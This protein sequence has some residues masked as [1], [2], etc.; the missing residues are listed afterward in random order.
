[1]YINYALQLSKFI[2]LILHVNLQCSIVKFSNGS[3]FYI[4]PRGTAR[5]N[6]T[7]KKMHEKL[8]EHNVHCLG[9]IG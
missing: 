4:W 8:L 2:A 1:M 9:M 5:R 6:R 3:T 7:T